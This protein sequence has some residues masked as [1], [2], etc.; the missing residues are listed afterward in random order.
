[1]NSL[2]VLFAVFDVR[3]HPLDL[4]NPFFIFGLDD[5]AVVIS[6]NVENDLVNRAFHRVLVAGVPV[7]YQRNGETRGDFVRLVDWHNTTPISGWR[8]SSSP[9]KGRATRAGLTLFCASKL[10]ICSRP[11]CLVTT[12]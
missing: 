9:S 11:H 7:Q 2:E 3:A 6:F 1:M 8:C 5:Q 12:A 10:K 4:D